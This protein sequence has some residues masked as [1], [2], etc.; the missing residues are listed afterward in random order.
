MTSVILPWLNFH[1]QFLWRLVFKL[2]GFALLRVRQSEAC[3]FQYPP[4]RD[5]SFFKS[6]RNSH[7]EGNIGMDIELLVCSVDSK[8]SHLPGPLKFSLGSF[9]F[10]N[11][12]VFTN[13]VVPFRSFFFFFI[14]DFVIHWNEIAMG[15]HVFPIPIPPPTSLSTHSL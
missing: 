14:V 6:V 1:K 4:I 13:W 12:I 10:L 5:N 8:S 15:L 7:L 11:I 3:L 2:Q 9:M